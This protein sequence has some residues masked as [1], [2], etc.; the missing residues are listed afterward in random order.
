MPTERPNRP[1]PRTHATVAFARSLVLALALLLP[2]S[3][4]TAGAQLIGAL[5]ASVGLGSGA[6]R[7]A[8]SAWRPVFNVLDRVV[9]S[10]G[11]RI[12]SYTGEAG[13]YTNRGTA[14]GSLT[15]TLSLSPQVYGIN[16]AVA[17]DVTVFGDFGVGF[18]L[19]LIGAATGA[20][21]VNGTL[22]AKPQ[23]GSL[24][25][26]GSPDKGALNSETYLSWHALP[27]LTVRAGTSHYVTNYDVT[28]P[29]A[30]GS[31]S[32]RYQKFVTVPFVALSFKF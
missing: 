20:N 24:F 27:T 30:A 14:S 12:T 6:Q 1:R 4:R 29:I 26:G 28:D 3:A 31:P 21:R 17:A 9:L 25:A 8:V 16:L 19:D 11:L 5:D 18:N 2:L 23:S 13:T 15:P 10:A 22:L 32:A 7:L